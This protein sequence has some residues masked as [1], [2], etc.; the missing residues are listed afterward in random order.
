MKS[1]ILDHPFCMNHSKV[2]AFTTCHS[3]G[4]PFCADCLNEGSLYFF[5]NDPTCVRAMKIAIENA[6]PF[7]FDTPQFMNFYWELRRNIYILVCVWKILSSSISKFVNYFVISIR[8]FLS[9]NFH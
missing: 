7:P 2:R 8:K 1:G 5:C 4:M 6:P 9:K 3:C